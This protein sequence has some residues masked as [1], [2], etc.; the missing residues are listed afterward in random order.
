MREYKKDGYK[1][2]PC[3]PHLKQGL[4]NI[5]VQNRK[6]ALRSFLRIFS[7]KKSV[8]KIQILDEI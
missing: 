8:K 3:S 1:R 7:P 2:L 5:L 4:N 6:Y